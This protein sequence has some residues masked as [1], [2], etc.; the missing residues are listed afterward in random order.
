MTNNTDK[1]ELHPAES[2]G[3]EWR[4]TRAVL[5]PPAGQRLPFRRRVD[6]ADDAAV[7]DTVS[8]AEVGVIAPVLAQALG[9]GGREQSASDF[10]WDQH[11]MPAAALEF[12]NDRSIGMLGGEGE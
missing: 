12:W 8:Q 6:V 4:P 7:F 10:R 9:A 11:G 2:N 1:A 3:R 5:L